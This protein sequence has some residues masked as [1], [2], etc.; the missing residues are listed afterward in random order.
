MAINKVVLTG[1]LTAEP[2]LRQTP[3]GVFVCP[4]S[5]AQN[6]GKDTPPDFF[7]CVAWRQTADPGLFPGTQGGKGLP[8][9]PGL[10]PGGKIKNYHHPYDKDIAFSGGVFLA[11]FIKIL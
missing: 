8:A 2:E 9:D 1:R 6:K 7:D 10:R 4:F 3:N 5:I 11:W